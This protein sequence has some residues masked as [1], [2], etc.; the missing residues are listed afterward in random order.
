MVSVVA[1]MTGSSVA[2]YAN[3]YQSNVSEIT[4]RTDLSNVESLHYLAILT[5]TTGMILLLMALSQAHFIAAYLSDSVVHGFTTAAAIHTI[6]SQIPK[7][8][9]ITIEI[10]SGWLKLYHV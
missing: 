1:L 10:R 3:E 4:K 9:G 5:F 2:K 7:V 8:L 6:W